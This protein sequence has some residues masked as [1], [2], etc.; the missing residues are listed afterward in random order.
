MEPLTRQ[1]RQLPT[2][3][4]TL[5]A[6]LRWGL[7]ALLILAAA[8]GVGFST[9]SA[10]EG[11]QYAFTNLG[12]EDSTEVAAALKA[13]DIPFRLDANGAAVAVPSA[14][15]YDARLLLAAS[16]LPRG[17]GTGFELFDRGDLGVSEFTQRVNLRRAIEGEVARTIGHLSGVR[18]ARVHVTLGEHGLYR[19]DE[20][21]ASASV[22][23]NLLPG[24]HL[25]DREISGI[26]H[27]VASSVAG[28]SPEAVTLV[29][30]TGR[31]LGAES[32]WA[33]A[34]QR[35]TERQMEQ[36]VVSLLEPVVGRGAVIA[37]VTAA[38]DDAEVSVQAEQFDP[39][40][41]AL[42]SERK[43]SQNQNQEAGAPIGIAGAAANQPGQPPSGATGSRGGS[44]SEEQVRNFEVNKTTT[45][46]VRHTPKLSRLSLA[47]LLDGVAGKPRAAEE[48]TRLGE[49]AKLAVG[50]DASRG[51]QLQISSEPFTTSAEDKTT[52]P[53]EAPKPFIPMSYLIG[54][55]AAALVVLLF[56]VVLITRRR[57]AGEPPLLRP[58]AKISEIENAMA[59]GAMDANLP[60][61]NRAA[62]L[63]GGDPTRAAHLLKAWIA[64]DG[65]NANV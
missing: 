54:G 3:L 19:E 59:P 62:E 65:E 39:D 16:G 61:R 46:T 32:T 31:V 52:A 56:I 43:S 58:G 9:M 51:D 6:G 40:S 33:G 15:V 23:V 44:A 1:L 55:G 14:K 28:L 27:L 26:R 13:A 36:Q 47:I 35:D 4:R 38:F 53:P 45:K 17:G 29:D 34:G 10:A 30:G 8:A 18:S 60:M 48:V 25:D 2:Q 49:L 11:F 41:S 12:P 24:R 57:S 37:K 20:H 7:V 63:V 42:R 50:F 5:P 64:A 21:K 22:V